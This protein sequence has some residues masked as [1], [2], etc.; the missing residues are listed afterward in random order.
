MSETKKLLDR[1]E[2]YL[3]DL[4]KKKKAYYATVSFRQGRLAESDSELGAGHLAEHLVIREI[5]Q[6]NASLRVGGTNSFDFIQFYCEGDSLT[7]ILEDFLKTIFSPKLDNNGWFTSEKLSAVNELKSGLIRLNTMTLERAFKLRFLEGSRLSRNYQ[8][9]LDSHQ[10]L[11]IDV[12]KNYYLEKVLTSTAV[13]TIGGY[14]ITERV[15]EITAVIGALKVKEN[16]SSN[17]KPKNTDLYSGRIVRQEVNNKFGDLTSVIVTFPGYS[18]KDEANKRRCLNGIC[19]LVCDHSKPGI[20]GD[21][22][23]LGIYDMYYDNFVFADYGVLTFS[24]QVE[25]KE[26]VTGFLEA[27]FDALEFLKNQ[28]VDKKLVAKRREELIKG[29]QENWRENRGR[30]QWIQDYLVNGTKVQDQEEYLIEVGKID[31]ELVRQTAREIFRGDRVN[32]LLLGKK[33][34]IEDDWLDTILA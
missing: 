5:R 32:I 19:Q 4:P 13:I 6:K 34:E 10:H 17:N 28:L 3:I 18:R 16:I 33:C 12:V 23:K 24:T 15:K 30:Y 20:I 31:P 27:I 2:T 8:D 7:M 26:Q 14:N 21:L 11:N 1:P 9:E 25:G 22:R 29:N